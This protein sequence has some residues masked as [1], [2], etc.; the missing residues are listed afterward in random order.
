MALELGN[1]TL[2]FK[3]TYTTNHLYQDRIFRYHPQILT[4]YATQARR[5]PNSVT[6]YKILKTLS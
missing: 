1:G 3:R 5:R 2:L 4:T 6:G